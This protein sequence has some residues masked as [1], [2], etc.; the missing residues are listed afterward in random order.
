M[1][2]TAYLIL[3]HIL[4]KGHEGYFINIKIKQIK[5][6]CWANDYANKVMFPFFFALMHSFSK[7][8]FMLHCF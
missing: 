8:K 7:V 1:D 2:F 4:Q 3:H 6:G 5:V